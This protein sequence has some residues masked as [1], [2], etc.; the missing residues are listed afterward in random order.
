MCG[1]VGYVGHRQ[2]AEVI[3]DGLTRLEYRGYDSAGVVI[4]PNR[5]QGG[6]LSVL[7]RAGT[8]SVLKNALV[9]QPLTGTLGLGH[10]RWAT[11]GKPNDVNA[12]PHLS[13]DARLAVIH[14]G[15]IEN[16]LPLK[17]RL[18]AEGHAF[19]SETDTE[20]IVHLIESYYQ[21]DLVAAVRRALK[22]VHGA[23]ALVVSHA[24]HEVIVAARATSPMVIG[25][26]ENENFVASDVPALLPYTRQ[27][28]FLH[29]GDMALM[30]R[31]AAIR[32]TCS[33]RFTSS[34]RCCKTPSA[35]A[36]RATEPTCSLGFPSTPRPSA[37]SS[38]P[39]PEPP[40]TRARWAST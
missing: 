32:T 18:Q 29:D 33:R 30:R 1:I 36:S 17:E 10:T 26:G 6:Q 40:T 19:A 28:I 9:T 22:D 14:N 7:K 2:A 12:H 16:Y 38:S 25:L 21:G 8:L 15:I 39:P 5:E 34:P 3:V 31:R 23:Y 27:V 37:A 35:G 24:E 20:V 4:A 11:H 13:E